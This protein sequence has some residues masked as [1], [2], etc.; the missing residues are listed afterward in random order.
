MKTWK[1]VLLALLAVSSVMLLSFSFRK[2][3]K[4]K[5]RSTYRSIPKGCVFRTL[6]GEESSD[7]SFIYKS[8]AKVMVTLQRGLEWIAKAQNNLAAQR[9]HLHV[10][11][12]FST[13]AQCP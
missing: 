7:S 11:E 9:Q 3:A 8:D 5:H 1:V 13:F 4:Y 10:G 6:M 2:E 12:L